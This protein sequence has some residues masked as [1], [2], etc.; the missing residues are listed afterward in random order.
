MMGKLRPNHPAADLM[1]KQRRQVTRR[2]PVNTLVK[3]D[4]DKCPVEFHNKYPFVR[5]EVLLYLG[6][7]KQMRGHCVVATKDGRVVWGYHTENFVML[8]SDYS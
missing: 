7:V 1:K 3:F 6:E 4:F 2:T 5:D 8:P